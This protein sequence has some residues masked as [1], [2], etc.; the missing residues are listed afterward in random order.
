[1][2][3]LSRAFGLVD[4]R[5]EPRHF[6]LRPFVLRGGGPGF[7][8]GAFCR[9]ALRRGGIVVD[10]SQD[11]GGKDVQ[12]LEDRAPGQETSSAACRE[13]RIGMI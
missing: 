3:D 2:L 6:D 8:A 13:S 10:S 1:M 7:V 12:V 11:D 5:A 9:V 4:G